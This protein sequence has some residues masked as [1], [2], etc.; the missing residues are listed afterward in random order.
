M[1]IADSE[2]NARVAKKILEKYGA[3]LK[4]QK[5][6]EVIDIEGLSTQPSQLTAPAGPIKVEITYR[7][8]RNIDKDVSAFKDRLSFRVRRNNYMIVEGTRE[9][10]HDLLLQLRRDGGKDIHV[11][12]I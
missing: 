7:N 3:I 10:I 8:V 6:D 2:E 4:V 5:L 12:F 11:E 9:N 1:R